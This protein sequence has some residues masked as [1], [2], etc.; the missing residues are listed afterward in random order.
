MIL[1]SISA[2]LFLMPGPG[3]RGMFLCATKPC[4]TR[5]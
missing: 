3:L 5:P 1:G 2:A 4:N